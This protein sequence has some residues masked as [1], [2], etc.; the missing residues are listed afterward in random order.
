M[1]DDLAVMISLLMESWLRYNSMPSV[2]SILNVGTLPVTW[3]KHG[4]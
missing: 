1:A 3:Q 2:L 4:T